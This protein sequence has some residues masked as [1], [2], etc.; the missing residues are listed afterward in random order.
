MMPNNQ[1]QNSFEG[2]KGYYSSQIQRQTIGRIFRYIVVRVVTILMTVG[3][4]LYIALFIL[5]LGGYVDDI[6]YGQIFEAVGMMA[7]G[8]AFDDVPED[9]YDE[10]VEQVI[11]DMAESMGLHEPLPIRTAR[12][13]FKGITLQ[14]GNTERLVTMDRKSNAVVDVVFESLPYTLMLAGAANIVLFF[15]SLWTAMVLSNQRGKFW[16]RLLVSL[17]PI[18]SAPSWIHGVILL[19]IFAL[20]LRILPFKGLYSGAPPENTMD[21]V[22]EILKHMV[23]PVMALFLSMFFQGVYTW[24][25]FFMVHS[26]EDYVE[27]AKA[28]G[29]PESLFRKRY[30]L[31]PT[32]PSIITSFAMMLISFWESAIALELLFNWPGLGALFYRALRVIDRPTFVAIFILFA[33]LLGLSV[34]FLDIIYAVIDPRVRINQ[35]GKSSRMRLVRNRNI[36]T[37]IRDLF[38]PKEKTNIRKRS[39][40]LIEELQ[41]NKP[42]FN[43]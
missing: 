10:F 17:T 13:W 21:L 38:K 35:N 18:S 12:W 16:D 26:G 7:Y 20:E 36:L 28:K 9:E 30:L 42:L 29:I 11:W 23:L 19:A 22:V 2:Q 40:Y 14:W 34:I 39:Q 15:S 43:H 32:L 1:V 27:L 4:G 31:R 41:P 3:L 8:G 6:M 5:N 33:Y 24:R 37:W 25:T